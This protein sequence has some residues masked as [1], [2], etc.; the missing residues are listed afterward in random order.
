MATTQISE[1]AQ[2]Q[3]TAETETLAGA[4]QS[5]V[6]TT[7]NEA[8]VAATEGYYTKKAEGDAALWTAY[9]AALTTLQTTLGPNFANT[10]ETTEQNFMS[11]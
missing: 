11:F 9:N 3:I 4:S 10:D 2:N 1:N 8:Q 7:N 5:T 6:A